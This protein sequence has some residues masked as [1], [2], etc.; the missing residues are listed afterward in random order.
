MGSTQQPKEHHPALG[1]VSR[2]SPRGALG[3]FIKTRVAVTDEIEGRK[4]VEAV[5]QAKTYN[6]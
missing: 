2:V 4:Y 3:E 6:N 1:V 5:Q